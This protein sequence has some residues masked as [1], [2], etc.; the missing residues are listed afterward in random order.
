MDSSRSHA[1]GSIR[2]DSSSAEFDGSSDSDASSEADAGNSGVLI[3]RAC[4]DSSDCGGNPCITEAATGW[5]RGYCTQSCEDG[6]PSGTHCVNGHCGVSCSDPAACRSDGYSCRDLDGDGRS[7][8]VATATGD[9]AIGSPCQHHGQCGGGARGSCT[10]EQTGF[11]DG[12]CTLACS[13]DEPCPSGSDCTADEDGICLPTCVNDSVCRDGY[14]CLPSRKHGPAYLCQPGAT[15]TGSIGDPCEHDFQCGGGVMGSCGRNSPGGFC[16]MS[17]DTEHPCPDGMPCL[18]GACGRHCA[19]DTDCRVAEGFSCNEFFYPGHTVCRAVATGPGALGD[20]CDEILDCGGGERGICVPHRGPNGN[21]TFACSTEHPCPEGSVCSRNWAGICIET[22]RDS[23][24]CPSGFAC[25][26]YRAENG[27]VFMG[28]GPIGIGT[29]AVGDPCTSAS[30]CSG[31][32]HAGCA[33]GYVHGY[34]WTVCGSSGVA[35]EPGSF[36]HD[37]GRFD[38]CVKS[39]TTI[40]DC[41]A[42]YECVQLREGRACMIPGT[43]IPSF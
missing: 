13:R 30:E 1:D 28:C 16:A 18:A 43:P 11:K 14:L 2:V 35:C 6:C 20:P 9:G 19:E 8:C 27:R 22:C 37:W 38:G 32:V 33:R 7:E 34:C 39:C 10:L 42:G 3:G 26:E 12:A 31:G 40:S 36:C 41:R 25:I 23:S 4:T 21:C 5:T 24:T 29:G 15:G 17:C